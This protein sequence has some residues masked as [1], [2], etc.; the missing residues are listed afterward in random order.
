MKRYIGITLIIFSLIGFIFLCFGVAFINHFKPELSFR[1]S[2][3]TL[4]FPWDPLHWDELRDYPLAYRALGEIPDNY[5]VYK[6]F[7]KNVSKLGFKPDESYFNAVLE[8]IRENYIHHMKDADLLKGCKKELEKLFKEAGI[9]TKPDMKNY[10]LDDLF[11]QKLVSE[12]GKKINKDLLVYASIRGLLRGLDDPYT[13][14]LTPKDYGT[15]MER[16]QEKSFGG[17]GI[18]IEA[19]PENHN[20]PTVIE[21]IEGTPAFRIG[22]QSGDIIERINKESTK[23]LDLE[24]CVAKLRGPKGTPVDLEIKRRGESKLLAFT[25][26]RAEISVPS[27]SYKVLNG[28]VGY[29]RIRMFGTATEHELDEAIANLKDKKV[30]SMIM[31]LRNNGGGY[32]NAAVDVSSR[33]V[34]NDAVVFKR[35]DKDAMIKDFHARECVKADVPLVLLVNRFSASSSEIVAGAIKDNKAGLL[36]GDRTFGKGSVQQIYPLISESAL[37]LTI[38]NFLTPTGKIINKRG[39]KP[40]IT[41]DMKPNM[42][43][44][45]LEKDIQLKKAI[46][47]LKEREKKPSLGEAGHKG[48]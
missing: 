33:F 30:K 42:V 2:D 14:L 3:F 31:D 24:T 38:S 5:P 29:I 41:V 22:L 26:L 4:I 8:I 44:K 46:S 23:D 16:L 7:L 34:V 47:L 43:G 6:P 27:V 1:K 12:Y 11:I 21:P 13:N 15:L 37:K 17:I 35:L 20:L 28:D 36:I 25:I 39:L 10:S 48:I 19:D 32:L 18:Y 40:D 45:G 9:K